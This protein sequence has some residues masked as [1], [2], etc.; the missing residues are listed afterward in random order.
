MNPVLSNETKSIAQTWVFTLNNPTDADKPDTWVTS[1]AATYVVWQMEVG[2]N[3]TPHYQGYVELTK[4]SRLSALKKLAPLAHWELRKGTQQQAID[5][6]K[7]EDT[8]SGG[9]WEAGAPAVKQQGKRTDLELACEAARDLGIREVREQHPTAYVKYYKGLTKIADETRRDNILKRE[10]DEFAEAELRPWQ[11]TLVDKLQRKPDPRKIH[12]YWEDEGNVGKTF[13][14]KYLM[15]TQDALVLDCSKKADLS[16]MIKD[17][18]G[19]VI[20]F[21]ITRTIGD[22]FMNHVYG[23]CESIKD[24]L[25]I[26]TKYETQRI[27]LGPQHVVVFSNREPDY[28]KW[29]QD[30]YDVHKIDTRTP[31]NQPANKK[32]ARVEEPVQGA[33]P[34]L[35][36]MAED[37]DCLL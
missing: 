22:D 4:R 11:Q 28:D 30:R 37:Y 26:S 19:A 5:Y 15:S 1:G 21:N 29:S 6:C 16:Y 23:L 24:D 18:T 34:P 10:R 7:K 27:A 12:W 20:L 2:A 14:A 8:R 25:V 17:H 32:R 13:V 31:W 3:G 33:S 9:P 36:I 35:R